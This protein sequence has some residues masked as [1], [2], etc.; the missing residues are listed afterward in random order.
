MIKPRGI[1]HFKPLIQFKGDWMIGVTDLEVNN[2]IFNITE[3]NNK[4]QLYKFPDE[5]SGGVSYEKV[6]DGMERVLD[7]SEI[8]AADIQDDLTAPIFINEYKR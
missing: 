5:K 2:S 4:L 8:T 7:F 6:R 1:F 3:E